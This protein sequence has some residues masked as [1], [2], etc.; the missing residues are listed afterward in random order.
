MNELPTYLLWPAENDG[1]VCRKR[2]VPGLLALRDIN[3]RRIPVLV[4][5]VLPLSHS[6]VMHHVDND[7]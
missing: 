5:L 4:G 6:S 1:D 3:L 2:F 7:L